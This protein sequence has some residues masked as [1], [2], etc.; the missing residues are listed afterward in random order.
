MLNCRHSAPLIAPHFAHWELVSAFTKLHGN[1]LKR[2]ET[3]FS[4]FGKLFANFGKLFANFG[5]LFANF[6]TL[7]AKFCEVKSLREP[8]SQW[9]PRKPVPKQS[10]IG[11]RYVFPT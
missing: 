6:G 8:M 11:S 3:I 4:N 1:G 7:F 10:P 5:K 2:F 9:R